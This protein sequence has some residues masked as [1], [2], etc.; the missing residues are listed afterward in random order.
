MIYYSLIKLSYFKL[1]K[2]VYIHQ[3]VL[4]FCFLEFIGL[5]PLLAFRFQNLVALKDSIH[6]L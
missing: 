3:R 1:I 6:F 5:S 4:Y 2:N